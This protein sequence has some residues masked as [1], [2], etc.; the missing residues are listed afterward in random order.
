M[1]AVPTPPALRD[2]ISVLGAG[3]LAFRASYPNSVPLGEGVRTI[4]ALPKRRACSVTFSFPAESWRRAPNLDFGDR[5]YRFHSI[6]A[7]S[8]PR[9]RFCS[10][11][12]GVPA[13]EWVRARPRGRRGAGSLRPYRGAGSAAARRGGR[14]TEVRGSPRGR[15]PLATAGSGSLAP[16]GRR[17]LHVCCW[18]R[19]AEPSAVQQPTLARPGPALE[20]RAAAGRWGG[21]ESR[22]KVPPRG[23][24][25][26]G[27]AAPRERAECRQS[28]GGGAA[29]GAAHAGPRRMRGAPVGAGRGG[30]GG[31]AA[32]AVKMVRA[33]ASGVGAA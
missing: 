16:R 3:S 31:A 8:V 27:N 2:P 9:E 10:E 12:R 25:G 22:R 20:P 19:P 33:A 26:A 18:Q 1:C 7:G 17:L 13:G 15:A 29:R 11:L 23:R 4:V 24:E 5:P 14:G 6:A 28:A 32:P 21:P 30:A